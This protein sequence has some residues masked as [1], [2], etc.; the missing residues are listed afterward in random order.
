M[1]SGH[2]VNL[3]SASLLVVVTVSWDIIDIHTSCT[4]PQGR[5]IAKFSCSFPIQPCILQVYLYVCN[6]DLCICFLFPNIAWL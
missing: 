3:A 6:S 2:L 4:V 5:A 1:V